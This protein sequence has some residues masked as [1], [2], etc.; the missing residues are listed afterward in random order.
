[1]ASGSTAGIINQA[2]F[3]NS[4]KCNPAAINTPKKPVNK[5]TMTTSNEVVARTSKVF[6]LK[7][8]PAISDT[9]FSPARINRYS[10]GISESATTNPAAVETKTL[11][12]LPWR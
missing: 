12:N 6:A 3:G 9:G 5:I 11:P 4:K 7:S 2:L 10:N 8:K 1:M